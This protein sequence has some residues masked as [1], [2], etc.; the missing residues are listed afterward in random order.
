MVALSSLRLCVNYCPPSPIALLLLGPQLFPTLNVVCLLQLCPQNIVELSKDG[1][2]H[3]TSNCQGVIGP[4]VVV[5]YSL[6]CA[7]LFATPWTVVCQA[8]VSMG[9]PRQE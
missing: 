9:F 1:L 4:L 7:Q 5:V 6:S 2:L 8:P 3:Y